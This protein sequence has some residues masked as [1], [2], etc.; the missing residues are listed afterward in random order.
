MLV[1]G[2]RSAR[3]ELL[4]DLWEY[5]PRVNRWAQLAVRDAVWEAAGAVGTAVAGKAAAGAPP[6]AA[7]DAQPLAPCAREGASLTYVPAAA[8]C[9]LVGGYV[10]RRVAS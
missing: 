1:F 4:D 10:Q 8:A 9:V 6:E 5:R 2:G 7:A 3:G